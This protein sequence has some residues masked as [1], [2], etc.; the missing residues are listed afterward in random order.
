MCCKLYAVPVLAKPENKWCQHCA[1]GK[2]CGIWEDRPDFCRSFHCHW[3]LDDDVGPEWKPE[4]CKFI[5]NFQ[6]GKEFWITVDSAHRLAWKQEPYYSVIKRWAA[7]F[8]A[9]GG[10]IIVVD[11]RETVCVLPHEDVVLGPY[12]K[13]FSYQIQTKKVGLT[14]VYTVLHREPETLA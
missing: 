14:T 10:S 12:G 3:L 4:V 2:G 6:T 13:P 8:L 11:G 7:D 1:P 9:A 5:M